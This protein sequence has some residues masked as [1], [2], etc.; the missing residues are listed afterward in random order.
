MDLQHP[1]FDLAESTS[2]MDS[3][4]DASQN[5]CPSLTMASLQF[6]RNITRLNYEKTSKIGESSIRSNKTQRTHY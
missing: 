2:S 1:R 6:S 4:S 5:D 3:D